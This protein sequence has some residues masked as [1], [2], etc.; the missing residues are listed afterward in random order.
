[1]ILLQR[2]A[3]RNG[4]GDAVQIKMLLL[5]ADVIIAANENNTTYGIKISAA[6]RRAKPDGYVFLLC[7]QLTTITTPS[8]LYCRV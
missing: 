5:P 4:H 3:K 8:A 2:T 6:L 7:F 1:M